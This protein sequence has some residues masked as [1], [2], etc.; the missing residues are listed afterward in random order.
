MTPAGLAE[1]LRI[2]P[3]R[4]AE[5]AA[6]EAASCIA[7]GAD[8]PRPLL[9]S[10][11]QMLDDRREVFSWVTCGACG[12]VYLSPRVPAERVGE[13]YADYL[14]H[15]GP[16]AWGHWAFLVR[17]DQWRL[18]RARLRTVQR[19]GPLTRASSVLDV[20]CGHPTFLARVHQRT[21]ARCV[22]VDFDANG[23]KVPSPRWD[24]LSLLEGELDVVA[25]LAPFDVITMWHALEHLYDPGASLRR[26][27]TMAKPATRLIIEVPDYD[28][29][30]RRRH[31]NRWAGFHTPRHTAAYTPESLRRLVER[32]GW[33]VQQQYQ[34]GTLHPHI[35]HWLGAQDI[36]G[37]SWRGS[38]QGRMIPFILGR[39]VT[40]PVTL[41]QRWL[42]LGVQT[43]VA[44]A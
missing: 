18:D 27:R 35:V 5:P 39:F 19:T 32:N 3:A 37:R 34:Y 43:L 7:C 22:G 1:N 44:T 21:G 10:P 33:R 25:P 13:Y 17:F 24:G 38:L 42:P 9:Q 29:L 23:W 26:L 12:Q 15:R 4:R 31:G 14:P 11:V 6:L 20:G 16:A 8:D 41:L 40:S 2:V 36:A 28:S 30:T